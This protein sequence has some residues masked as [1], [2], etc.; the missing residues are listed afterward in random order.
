MVHNMKSSNEALL[1]ENSIWSGY[2]KEKE[3]KKY[4]RRIQEFLVP[5]LNRLSVQKILEVGCGNG[6]APIQL[7]ENGFDCYGIAPEFRVN[8]T[9]THPFLFPG[10][11]KELHMFPDEYFDLVYSLEVI[12]HVGTLDGRLELS[13]NYSEERKLF[14][15]ELCRVAKRYVVIA[16]PN[17]Y[18]IVDE[19][20]TD[21]KGKHGFRF[22]SPFEKKT[23]STRELQAMFRECGFSNYSFIGASG[24]YELERI[25]NKMGRLGVFIAEKL[26]D[27]SSNK[28]LGG[29][30]LSP[31]LFLLFE[32]DR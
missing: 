10:E 21:H 28:Y 8:I 20:G 6:F 13:E 25:E 15:K 24:Y 9:E 11:G 31:H 19:H 3:I 18:F 17:K 14:V 1:K 2:F 16:T 27:I 30:F 32:R 12:E 26:L 29:S 22:H 5:I 23:L 4:R 7:R